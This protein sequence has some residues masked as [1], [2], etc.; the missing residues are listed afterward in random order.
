MLIE[1]CGFRIL[2][3]DV[4]DDSDGIDLRWETTRNG[5][6]RL[7]DVPVRA[8]W[9]RQVFRA[10]AELRNPITRLRISRAQAAAY[11]RVVT[12]MF[13]GAPPGPSLTRALDMLRKLGKSAPFP[14][15]SELTSRT[16]NG[17]LISQPVVSAGAAREVP[18][19]TEVNP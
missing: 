6:R 10:I 18:Q 17:T 12:E 9:L 5:N 2:E 7:G 16:L 8:M 15:S 13:A 19:A 3:I 14:L 4:T 11:R 1:A